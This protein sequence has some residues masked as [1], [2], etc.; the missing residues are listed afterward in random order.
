MSLS[1]FPNHAWI[2]RCERKSNKDSWERESSKGSREIGE[3][4]SMRLTLK[5]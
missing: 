5:Y 3:D 2:Y 1:V 4:V